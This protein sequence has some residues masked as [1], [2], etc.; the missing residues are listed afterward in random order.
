MS[1]PSPTRR[2]VLARTAAAVTAGGAAA[3][4]VGYAGSGA[5]VAVEADDRF[6]AEDVRVERNDGDLDAVTVA[7]ELEVAWRDFGGGLESIDV[8]LSAAIENEPGFDVLFDAT[9]TETDAI[10]VQGDGLG[11]VS[12]TVDLAMER[13][14]L[15]A[16]GDDVT[17]ADFGGDLAPGESATTTVELTLRVDVVGIQGD[18]VTAFETVPFD[19]TVHNPEGE[20]SATGRAKTGAE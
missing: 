15:T 2:T 14:D 12:G 4:A 1:T 5:A 16:T 3:V 7:P 13:R 20:A 17:T 19:V 10:A 9:A 18:A 8:T 11:S 6:L